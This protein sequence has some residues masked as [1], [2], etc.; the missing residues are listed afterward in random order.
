MGNSQSFNPSPAAAELLKQRERELAQVTGGDGYAEGAGFFGDLADGVKSGARAVKNAA[1]AVADATGV[2]DILATARDEFGSTAKTAIRTTSAVT[3]RGM[4]VA[5]N[6]LNRV[7]DNAGERATEVGNLAVDTAALAAKG[8]ISATGLEAGVPPIAITGQGEFAVGG[9]DALVASISTKLGGAGDCVQGAYESFLVRCAGGAEDTDL[10]N[11]KENLSIEDAVLQYYDGSAAAKAKRHLI[12]ALKKAAHTVLGRDGAG[13][14]DNE[15]IEI[16][17]KKLPNPQEEA[18]QFKASAKTHEAICKT[19]ARAINEAVGQQVIPP[20]SAPEIVCRQVIEVLY[21]LQK[22]LQ[23]EFLVVYSNTRRHL[24]NLGVLS[25]LMTELVT[26]AEGQVNAVEPGPAKESAIQALEAAKLVKE[27]TARQLEMLSANVVGVLGASAS[28]VDAILSRRKKLYRL[29]EKLSPMNPGSTGFSRTLAAAMRGLADSALMATAVDR[30]LKQAGMS[31]SEYVSTKSAKDLQAAIDKLSL[32]GDAAAVRL[33][34]ETLLKYHGMR[35][36]LTKGA[37]EGGRAA[38]GLD[39]YPENINVKKSLDRQDVVLTSIMRSFVSKFDS[40][41]QLFVGTIE[42]LSKKMGTLGSGSAIAAT[43]ALDGFRES[44]RG[45][46]SIA[47]P[48]SIQALIGY[49]VSP[50]SES[51]RNEFVSS[52]ESAITFSRALAEQP[53]FSSLA[54]ELR[55]LAGALEGL[56]QAIGSFRREIRQNFVTPSV[57]DGATAKGG[58]VLSE[59]SAIPP[60][61]LTL[62]EKPLQLSMN[63]ST[64]RMATHIEHLDY[65]IELAYVRDDFRHA[66]EMVGQNEEKAVTI[67]AAAIGAKITELRTQLESRLKLVLEAGDAANPN[68]GH[69]FFEFYK[70]AGGAAPPPGRAA[71]PAAQY[72]AAELPRAAEVSERL[73]TATG[74]MFRQCYLA[75]VNLFRVLESFDAYM[76]AFSGAI[77]KHPDAL[78]DLAQL[79]SPARAARQWYSPHTGAHI[80]SVFECFPSIT[81][82]QQLAAPE[83]GCPQPLYMLRETPARFSRGGRH[84]YEAIRDGLAAVQNPNDGVGRHPGNPYAA[85]PAT[86][87]L[88]WRHGQ[89]DAA[90]QLRDV[91]SGM[92]VLKNLVSAFFY[93]GDKFG[94]QSLRANAL[95][96][97]NQMYDYLMSY[98]ETSAITLRGA[99]SRNT[100]NVY[101]GFPGGGAGVQHRATARMINL[102][103]FAQAHAQHGRAPA[104]NN[105]AASVAP[106]VTAAAGAIDDA[107][108]RAAGVAAVAVPYT[109]GHTFVGTVAPSADGAA[110]SFTADNAP[111]GEVNLLINTPDKR[112]QGLA[113][114]TAAMSSVYPE[115]G[116]MFADTD[117]YFYRILRGMA[118]KVMAV[119][120][121]HVMLERPDNALVVDPVRSA[122]GAAESA[123]AGGAAIE[124]IPEASPLY[125]YGT[126]ALEFFKDL[127]GMSNTSD[128]NAAGVVDLGA[129]IALLP[130]FEGEFAPLLNLM[131][132]EMRGQNA[133]D[134]A[135]SDAQIAALIRE[136]NKLFDRHRSA[137]P[138]AP[139]LA[140]FAIV[141]EINRRMSLLTA[142]DITRI[143]ETI[144]KR[145]RLDGTNDPNFAEPLLDDVELLPNEGEPTSSRSLP[146]D[147]F[148]QM[149]S[150]T[151][152]A[153]T[154]NRY[155]IRNDDIEIVNRLRRRVDANVLSDG[156]NVAGVNRDDLRAFLRD[157]TTDVKEQPDNQKRFELVASVLRSRDYSL[158]TF[159]ARNIISFHEV[160]VAPLTAL[161][162]LLGF[163]SE[164][165]A[166]AVEHDARS[167]DM[168]LDEIFLKAPPADAV[169]PNWLFNGIDFAAAGAAG[170]ANFAV[171]NNAT[172]ILAGLNA[173]RP[174]GAALF[175]LNGYKFDS[176]LAQGA[177]N[178]RIRAF[179]YPNYN[180]LIRRYAALAGTGIVPAA[181]VNDAFPYGNTNILA[182]AALDIGP[183][184]ATLGQPT[185]PITIAAADGLVGG[186]GAAAAGMWQLLHGTTFAQ[187]AAADSL[188]QFFYESVKFALLNREGLMF[189]LADTIAAFAGDSQGLVEAS[190]TDRQIY[191]DYSKLKALCWDLLN[192]VRG[193]FNRFRPVVPE[194][195][196]RR[197]L[198]VAA[199]QQGQQPVPNAANAPPGTILGAEQIFTRLFERDERLPENKS[200]MADAVQVLSDNFNHGIRAF[201]FN[202]ELGVA[203]AVSAHRL[204]LNAGA[205]AAAL[206]AG[207]RAANIRGELVARRGA[208]PYRFLLPA[209]SFYPVNGPG[210]GSLNQSTLIFV[211]EDPGPAQL[212]TTAYEDEPTDVWRLLGTV[213][214]AAAMA[215][216]VR[217][218]KANVLH[219]L[220]LIGRNQPVKETPFLAVN[221]LVLDLLDTVYDQTAEKIPR[222]VVQPFI[223]KLSGLI[224]DEKNSFPDTLPPD[225]GG[226]NAWAT[227]LARPGAWINGARV[228]TT[229]SIHHAPASPLAPKASLV[230]FSSLATILRNAYYNNDTSGKRINVWESAEEIPEHIKERMRAHLPR[231]H[232]SLEIVRAKI[233][234]LRALLESKL[235]IAGDTIGVAGGAAVTFYNA[236]VVTLHSPATN[237]GSNVSLNPAVEGCNFD[238]AYF[239]ELYRSLDTLAA[240]TQATIISAL[241]AVGKPAQFFEEFAGSALVAT[242]ASGRKPHALPSTL[243]LLAAPP[244]DMNN[245]FT[246]SGIGTPAFKLAYGTSPLFDPKG[247]SISR[248]PAVLAAAAQANAAL[249][250][251]AQIDE[252]TA[253]A[254]FGSYLRAVRYLGEVNLVK[255]F[256]CVRSAFFPILAVAGRANHE[257]I[258]SSPF[259][260]VLQ[261]ASDAGGALIRSTHLSPDA[262]ALLTAQ[263]VA[264]VGLFGE[265]VDK[266]RL[267]AAAIT[268]LAKGTFFQSAGVLAHGEHVLRNVLAF[269][270]VPGAQDRVRAAFPL[271]LAHDAGA[272][273]PIL[274]EATV[275]RIT[276]L[277]AS[278]RSS[279]L[280]PFAEYLQNSG[281]SV[282][283]RS[284]L[285]VRTFLALRIVP[286]QPS[287]LSREIPFAT[288]YNWDYAFGEMLVKLIEKYDPAAAQRWRQSVAAGTL[289]AANYEPHSPAEAL[290][291]SLLDP[292][293]PTVRKDAFQNFF[294]RMLIG[295]DSLPISRP[296]MLS[297]AL[298]NGALM[299][300][301]F[302]RDVWPERYRPGG[303][304]PVV[305][306]PQAM[307]PSRWLQS[308]QRVRDVVDMLVRHIEAPRRA[309]G[310]TGAFLQFVS[311]N[312]HDVAIDA[313]GVLARKMHLT[314]TPIGAFNEQANAAEVQAV[315]DFIIT[316][317]L[318]R[319]RGM[320][321]PIVAGLINRNGAPAL[322]EALD[323]ATAD[324]AVQAATIVAIAT[325]NNAAAKQRAAK[326]IAELLVASCILGLALQRDLRGGGLSEEQAFTAAAAAI[327]PVDF[328]ANGPA[329]TWET[330]GLRA[331]GADR[332]AP[333]FAN[334]AADAIAT[335]VHNDLHP[336]VPADAGGAPVLPHAGLLVAPN[337][338]GA[339]AIANWQARDWRGVGARVWTDDTVAIVEA[340]IAWSNKFRRNNNANGNNR[341][342]PTVLTV[343]GGARQRN[344]IGGIYADRANNGALNAVVNVGFGIVD[345]LACS[346][347]MGTTSAEDAVST[348]YYP[349]TAA[350]RVTR[351]DLQAV[352]LG[353]D[354][355]VISTAAYTRYTTTFVRK[356]IFLANLQRMLFHQIQVSANDLGKSRVIRGLVIGD[357]RLTDFHSNE[358]RGD[359]RT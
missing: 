98:L 259:A 270:H 134:G 34:G 196:S 178:V 358:A 111:A 327:S 50:A 16:F 313:A 276:S 309:G 353:Q 83:R 88:G 103:G 3:Q 148:A 335:I 5:A 108:A 30:A 352:Q 339:A 85:I 238:Q 359:E 264:N 146:S 305:A 116:N 125:L 343:D 232:N 324:P 46:Q 226:A 39:A 278:S 260:R 269:Y 154:A 40:A 312:T 77:L 231:V 66:A 338:A 68:A 222:M 333:Q 92:I 192:G 114:V 28:E 292:N 248:F 189:S 31:V 122:L 105:L 337:G 161:N 282:A 320:L 311:A 277:L 314:F 328:I 69:E 140:V 256:L 204:G 49:V 201:N 63:K 321:E 42:R 298:Y 255:R 261:N 160:V 143:E 132:V 187:R 11:T 145:S 215:T 218:Y 51:L 332:Y 8:E 173:R 179:T 349:R 273:A 121:V 102:D 96:T 182:G 72:P 330:A 181:G 302:A 76:R 19:L 266:A 348:L 322:R 209:L 104:R 45:I 86:A 265:P 235:P 152:D 267:I 347:L 289:P 229:F 41:F 1:G 279:D 271:S 59:L 258:G 240:T 94:D 199:A 227:G 194:A 6:S 245:Y 193:A 27:E 17:L 304:M 100:S 61:A 331:V 123:I 214:T 239:N 99:D 221:Q 190:V 200:I 15:I 188:E 13:A 300:N 48:N 12:E 177:A 43:D 10:V 151:P 306:S 138:Q 128:R 165:A 217:E 78:A 91:F 120:G 54:G 290:L 119:M 52:L 263:A 101:D 153:A 342:G 230:L 295:D 106:W 296:K 351:N 191:L 323:S 74:K 130:D 47:Y 65:Y 71:P 203:I 319:V 224:S 303:D 75:K 90:K 280:A 315:N 144:T 354:R 64:E 297:D 62:I 129:K 136:F 216:P 139:R 24:A 155:L 301:T 127:L 81:E 87:A 195:L 310:A 329:A 158:G 169:N 20:D 2:S 299:G 14:K 97:P 174:Q 164:F 21:S 243:L 171:G 281:G 206:P 210:S 159:S 284:A 135:Y 109:A 79:F 4:G 53:D 26:K 170:A 286:I 251:S 141:K 350:Q 272:E 340:I 184:G 57:S 197:Y 113:L 326:E 183:R 316:T 150:M 18:G 345:W 242:Q 223:E 166:Q 29:V 133:R 33:A 244:A 142:A 268:G 58:D 162:A 317:V 110:A 185:V 117:E 357:P 137:G 294:A 163:T 228:G 219:R 107:M 38:G 172:A 283:D 208:F 341:A 56:I 23:T 249:P 241:E 225:G 237:V 126:F 84:Y 112:A 22:G 156:A 9:D 293:N 202:I 147:R 262:R 7:V 198:G 37:A 35:D 246:I 36:Q 168:A 80:A 93:I 44:L 176:I 233:K 89:D 274:G 95:L 291:L 250:S 70:L 236:A 67:N 55:E 115:V 175:R 167:F 32:S 186:A 205:A 254:L 60:A 318:P 25:D 252:A 124:V 213:R 307:Q 180:A 211:D 149:G 131:F 253:K 118:A 220:N 344:I 356:L 288:T 346:A 325:G 234:F 157:I 212:S 334:P 285:W 257:D 73:K 308:S 82:E 247:V 207:V 336:A 355:G 275:G 287:I